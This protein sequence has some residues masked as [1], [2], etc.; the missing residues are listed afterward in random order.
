MH[1][2]SVNFRHPALKMHLLQ[3]ELGLNLNREMA[4]S[5]DCGKAY[6]G[7]RNSNHHS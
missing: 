7:Y 2:F 6:K 5:H 1:F 3:I 4:F